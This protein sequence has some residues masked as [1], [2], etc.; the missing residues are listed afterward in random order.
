MFMFNT[1]QGAEIYSKL[2]AAAMGI[3]EQHKELVCRDGKDRLVR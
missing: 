3:A 1:K 2:H